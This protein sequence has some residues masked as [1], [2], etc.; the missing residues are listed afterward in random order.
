MQNEICEL[1]FLDEKSGTAI[2]AAGDNIE[3]YKTQ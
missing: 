1:F 3:T 2:F